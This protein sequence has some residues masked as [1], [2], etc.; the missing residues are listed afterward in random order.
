MT[1]SVDGDVIWFPALRKAPLLG[2]KREDGART[3]GGEG[4]KERGGDWWKGERRE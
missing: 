3:W 1:L 4:R 2:T